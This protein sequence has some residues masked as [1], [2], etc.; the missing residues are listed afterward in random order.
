MAKRLRHT[1]SAEQVRTALK[2]VEPMGAML[3]L[4][5]L[6]I[7][8]HHPDLVKAEHCPVCARFQEEMEAI[9]DRWNDARARAMEHWDV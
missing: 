8:A 3:E 6:V 9:L 5:Q 1:M 7:E 2:L 4:S